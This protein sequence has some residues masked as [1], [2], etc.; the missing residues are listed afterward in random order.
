M[1]FNRLVLRQLAI[2]G[3]CYIVSSHTTSYK[4]RDGVRTKYDSFSMVINIQL[5]ICTYLQ[6]C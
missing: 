6:V 2:Y 4:R 3:H 1:C 5:S